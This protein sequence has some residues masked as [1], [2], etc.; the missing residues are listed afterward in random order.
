MKKI[1]RDY[2]KIAPSGPTYSRGVR[3]GNLLFIAGCTTRGTDSQGKP[4]MEQLHRAAGQS[5]A[6]LVRLPRPGP[7]TLKVVMMPTIQALYP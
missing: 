7:P 1:R 5:A 2:P 6:E 4:L 3:T